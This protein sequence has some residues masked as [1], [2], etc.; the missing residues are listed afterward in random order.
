MLTLFHIETYLDKPKKSTSQSVTEP[1]K[2]N[3]NV[4][5]IIR[6]EWDKEVER[7]KCNFRNYE[8]G[9]PK[10]KNSEKCLVQSGHAEIE[11]NKMLFIYGNAMEVLKRGEFYSSVEEMY[12]E[13]VRFDHIVHHSHLDKIKQFVNLKKLYLSYNNLYSLILLS[14]LEALQTLEHLVIENNDILKCDLLKSFVVYRFQ[15][16]KYFNNQKITEEDKAQ[17]KE[18]FHLFDNILSSV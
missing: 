11:S 16:L 12:L 5:K 8:D 13:C 2:E 18:N 3:H 6:K 1:P 17:T 7:L 10:N 9:K 14:K 4:I 15:H